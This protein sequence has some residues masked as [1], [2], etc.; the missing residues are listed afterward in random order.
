VDGLPSADALQKRA[1]T[2]ADGHDTSAYRVARKA[3]RSLVQ[4]GWAFGVLE[5][6][7]PIDRRGFGR[8]DLG[9]VDR[10]YAIGGPARRSPVPRSPRARASALVPRS[11]EGDEAEHNGRSG[12]VPLPAC[13]ERGTPGPGHSLSGRDR[14]FTHCMILAD[15]SAADPPVFVSSV[16][17]W[18][19]GDLVMIRPGREFRILRSDQQHED[20]PPTMACREEGV[21][22]PRERAVVARV[23]FRRAMSY[24]AIIRPASKPAPRPRPWRCPMIRKSAWRGDR[25]IPTSTLGFAVGRSCGSDVSDATAHLRR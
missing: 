17:D 8:R 21:R 7:L 19:V 16:P 14:M 1:R 23:T 25:S 15:G 12:R 4:R 3:T 18:H 6:R 2:S 24:R 10:V 11:C 9:H 5:V 13:G 22:P 20:E